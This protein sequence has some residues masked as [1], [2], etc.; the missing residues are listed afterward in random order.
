MPNF[1]R[2]CQA[3]PCG[4]SQT[5]RQPQACR[6]CSPIPSPVAPN[7]TSLQPARPTGGASRQSTACH[8]TRAMQGHIH[9]SHAAPSEARQRQAKPKRAQ[10]RQAGQ[11]KAKEAQRSLKTPSD[12]YRAQL[13]E[14]QSRQAQSTIQRQRP[15]EQPPA[16]LLNAPLSLP[17][18]SGAP[19]RARTPAPRPS[20][21]PL[22]DPQPS[23]QRQAPN[24]EWPTNPR[25]KRRQATPAAATRS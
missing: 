20:T 22:R 15:S 7:P 5:P 21:L 13:R 23:R 12:A 25:A 24:R 8:S 14:N 18:A 2:R 16:W 10:P 19:P 4:Q 17:P 1:A 3:R 9:G 6:P 11:S